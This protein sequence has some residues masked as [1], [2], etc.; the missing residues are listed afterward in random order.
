MVK[1]LS[2]ALLVPLLLVSCAGPKANDTLLLPAIR[3]AWEGVR[4]DAKRGDISITALAN[5]DEAHVTGNFV[6]LETWE[7]TQAVR[8]GVDEMLIAG[9]IGPMG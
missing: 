1:M 4:E 7:V 3:T 9:E 8:F 6:G 2:K 5:W